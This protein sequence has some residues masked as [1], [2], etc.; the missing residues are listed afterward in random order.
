MKYFSVDGIHDGVVVLE[1]ENGE[2]IV[3]SVEKLPACK[4][5][6]VLCEADGVW[7]MSPDET[8]KRRNAAFVLEQKLRNKSK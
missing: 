5:D 6:D 1:D 4:E 2:K 3:L 8:A 7:T